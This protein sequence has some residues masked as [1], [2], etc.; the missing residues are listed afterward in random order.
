MEDR[1]TDKLPDDWNVTWLRMA[2]T[3]NPPILHTY[4]LSTN[5]LHSHAFPSSSSTNPPSR[6]HVPSISPIHFIQHTHNP[7]LPSSLRFDSIRSTRIRHPPNSH[8]TC[9]PPDRPSAVSC[10]VLFVTPGTGVTASKQTHHHPLTATYQPSYPRSTAIVAYVSY[11]PAIFTTQ[12]F[13]TYHSTAHHS[14][15]QPQS[16]PAPQSHPQPQSQRLTM[17]RAAVE[18]IPIPMLILMLRLSQSCL[19]PR[20]QTLL[21][22][23][24]LLCV[25][26]SQQ[27]AW[28]EVGWDRESNGPLSHTQ[29]HLSSRR[30]YLKPAAR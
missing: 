29:T 17:L 25:L 11:T 1:G 15:S 7:I 12:H 16:P 9:P 23:L 2:S 24:I 18:G 30:R 6:R 19:A 20:T 8:T 22:F 21:L 27:P 28:D 5:N 14:T 13:T 4:Y 26:V 10:R 3:C